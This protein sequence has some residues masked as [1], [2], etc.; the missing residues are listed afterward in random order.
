[1][2]LFAFP[3]IIAQALLMFSYPFVLRCTITRG[4][5]SKMVC[6]G[7]MKEVKYDPIALLKL[8]G[9]TDN[10]AEANQVLKV[11]LG[12]ARSDD[13]ELLSELSDPEV[14]AFKS[15]I[16]IAS[17]PIVNA[18]ENIDPEQ[19]FFLR[20]RCQDVQESKQL[21]SSQKDTINSKLIP[22]IPV[23]CEAIELH[24]SRV[25]QAI[26]NDDEEKQDI[27]SLICLQFLQLAKVADLKEEGSRRHFLYLMKQ[28]LSSIETPD[29]LV[30]GC[31]HA[32]RMVC[33]READMLDIVR[34]IVEAIQNYDEDTVDANEEDLGTMKLVRVL[35]ILT[36]ILE[37]ATSQLSTNPVLH[38]FAKHI[39][40][41]VT[42][43]D[44]FVREAAVGCF[45]K[46]GLF[47]AENTI[48]EEFKPILLQVANQVD[49]KMEIRAQAL[50]ALS[51]WSMLF[52]DVLNPCIVGSETICFADIV[53]DMMRDSRTACVCIASEVAAKLLFSGRVCD[54]DWLAQLL[55]IFFDPRMI[56]LAE[57]DDDVK[58]VGSPVRL[59]QLLTIFFPGNYSVCSWFSFPCLAFSPTNT[60]HCTRQC[61]IHTI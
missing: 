51:D 4:A 12:A 13:D 32:L 7:W 44:A 33:D 35:S 56:D 59:Q 19:L 58:E 36:V 45:G 47:T 28:M 10:E 2:T 60:V 48:I 24:A 18:E 34:E 31:I 3:S 22:D 11:V 8:V 30:E 43:S 52:S 21:T 20:A 27:E 50:L 23:L 17:K 1:M 26:Q 57:D 16:D 6:T 49:E 55:A 42:H 54:S 5:W 38:D 41:S 61:S 25:V 46:L 40:P 29:D 39:V 37:T 14:R 9:V 15:G 53:Q